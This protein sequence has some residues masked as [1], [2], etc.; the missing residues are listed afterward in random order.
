MLKVVKAKMFLNTLTGLWQTGILYSKL[1]L[2]NG[3]LLEMMLNIIFLMVYQ[4]T[5][6][7]LVIFRGY[8]INTRSTV[9]HLTTLHAIRVHSVVVGIGVRPTRP[10]G[11]EPAQRPAV[12]QIFATT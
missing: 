9:Y 6:M 11:N 8:T 10:G 2:Q 5:I 1:G 12:T 7:K 4:Y 3:I